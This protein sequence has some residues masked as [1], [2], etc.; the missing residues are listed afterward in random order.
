MMEIWTIPLQDLSNDDWEGLCDGCG[1]C[2]MHKF[3]DEETGKVYYSAIACRL[4]DGTSCR[5]TGYEHRCQ[6]VAD[7]IDIRSLQPHQFHWLPASC[8]YRLRFEGKPL[9]DWHPLLTGSGDSV[10]SS[11]NSMKNRCVPEQAIPEEHWIDYVIEES[12]LSKDP[13]SPESPP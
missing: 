13:Y 9:P 7:C 6:H 4:F 11:G 12:L 2:C 8:S 3:E 10:H 5:C 1:Q